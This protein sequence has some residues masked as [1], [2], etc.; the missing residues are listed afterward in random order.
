V[1]NVLISL[2]LTARGLVRSRA[3]RHLE[4][5]ALRHQ[6]QVLGRSRPRRLRITKPDRWLWTSLSRSWTA[7]RTAV[8]IVK[9]ET[10]LAWHRQG[11]R[12]SWTW[13]S[14]RRSGRPTVPNDLRALIRTMSDSNPLWGAPRIHGEWLKLGFDISQAS[15]A[16]YMRPRERP[17]SHSWRT[18]LTNH[19]QQIA[20]ADF[21][22]V[23]T[24]TCRLLF[25]LVILAH[26]RR[27][28]VHVAVTHHPTSAWTAQ[29][30][31]EACPLDQAPRYLVHDH[32]TAFQAWATAAT[33]LGIAE[34]LTAVRS[35]WQNSYAERLIGSIRRE[36]LDHVVVVNARGLRRVLSAYVEYS[37]RFR[38]HLSLDK[39]APVS[40][41]VAPTDRGGIVAIPQLGGL[42][43]H[44]E[45]RAA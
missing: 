7:W 27:R 19:L 4:V 1:L 29:Q 2:L 26:E 3:A 30:L 41:P 17:P 28:I 20:A 18:F 32:D 35:P 9:P 5:L 45:R 40:R 10:V 14:R 25:V 24:A 42:H 37:L 13:K 21:F 11:F 8:V 23:P 36:C 43:H 16:K 33:A 22:V 15:V 12:L 39:D 38:T 31:R 44:Y 34:V 6:L